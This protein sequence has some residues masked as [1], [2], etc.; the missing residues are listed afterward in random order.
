MGITVI[1]AI[2]F[3]FFLL[4]DVLAIVRGE[5]VLAIAMTAIIVVGAASLWM[6]WVTSP[7]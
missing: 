7:M 5:R 3:V 4:V 1:L 2:A 6:L